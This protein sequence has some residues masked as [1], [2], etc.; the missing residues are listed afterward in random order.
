VF[1]AAVPSRVYAQPMRV[2]PHPF[3]DCPLVLTVEA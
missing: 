3:R 1:D 2:I